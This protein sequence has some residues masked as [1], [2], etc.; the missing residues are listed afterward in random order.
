M[1]S[2]Q[3]VPVGRRNPA[4][5]ADHLARMAVSR[6]IV[7]DPLSELASGP[8]KRQ[9]A[10]SSRQP[11]PSA[12]GRGRGS[13]VVCRSEAVQGSPTQKS[14]MRITVVDIDLMH[15]RF[16]DIVL[17]TDSLST[18]MNECLIS[19]DRPAR[20]CYLELRRLSARLLAP[21]QKDAVTLRCV[22]ELAIVLCPSSCITVTFVTP[23]KVSIVSL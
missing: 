6:V 10:C 20:T 3:S 23:F 9:V 15:G 4:I 21:M 12:G 13:R 19:R 2:A 18:D 16:A 8:M 1:L 5:T 14:A 7:A 11:P 22:T 17:S